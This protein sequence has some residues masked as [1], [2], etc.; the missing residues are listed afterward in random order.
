MAPLHQRRSGTIVCLEQ[1]RALR[2][3]QVDPGWSL[4]GMEERLNRGPLQEALGEHQDAIGLMLDE[5]EALLQSSDPARAP[6]IMLLRWQ[7]T[8]R[9][10]SYQEFKHVLLFDPLCGGDDTAVA[11]LASEMRDRCVGT[12]DAY[13]S[14]VKTWPDNSID[15]DWTSYKEAKTQVVTLLRQHLSREKQDAEQLLW[16]RVWLAPKQPL[17]HAGS[18]TG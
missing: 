2:G 8:K 7:L 11:R 18:P 3:E 14:H 13:A 1:D 16:A 6:L 15:A 10:R 4:I 5:V 17:P 12:G 9:L